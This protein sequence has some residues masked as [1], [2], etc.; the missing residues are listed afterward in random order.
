MRRHSVDSTLNSLQAPF[1][2][3]AGMVVQFLGNEGDGPPGYARLLVGLRLP[4]LGRTECF[5]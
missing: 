2:R 1:I 4:L 5:Q 3:G